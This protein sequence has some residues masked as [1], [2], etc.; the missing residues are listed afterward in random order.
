MVLLSMRSCVIQYCY[1]NCAS[2]CYIFC[3]LRRGMV[4]GEIGMLEVVWRC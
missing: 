1:Y 4:C 2:L 3:S